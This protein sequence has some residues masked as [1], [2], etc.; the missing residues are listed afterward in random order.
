MGGCGAFQNEVDFRA[1]HSQR[2]VEAYSSVIAVS[3]VVIYGEHVGGNGLVALGPD[4][5][6]RHRVAVPTHCEVRG[7]VVGHHNPM[8]LLRLRSQSH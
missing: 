3:L 8:S 7:G 1:S 6:E 4:S 2:A 5:E